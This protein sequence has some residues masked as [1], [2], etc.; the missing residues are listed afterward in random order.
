LK[1]I[2]TNNYDPSGKHYGVDIV[3]AKNA[4]IKSTLDGTVIFA[5]WTLQTGY[6]IAVQHQDNLISVYKHNSV[7]LKKEG[8]YVTAGAVIAIIGET[9]EL[10]TGPHLH[11]ELWY[12]GS[13]VNPRDYM[14]FQ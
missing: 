12:D 2:I 6:T 5:E 8:D 11:F 7:L 1:G 10:T 9:G 13:P 4:A 3:A 14:V